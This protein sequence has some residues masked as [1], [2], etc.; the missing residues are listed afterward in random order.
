VCKRV[1]VGRKLRTTQGYFG[2]AEPGFLVEERQ[3]ERLWVNAKVIGTAA[4]V[5]M[6]NAVKTYGKWSK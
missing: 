2:I 5:P 1:A 4:A 6:M 3:P